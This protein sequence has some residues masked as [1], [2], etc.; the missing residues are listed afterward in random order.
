MDAI[1]MQ[2]RALEESMTKMPALSK[3]NQ[4]KDELGISVLI[5]I[6]LP[7]KILSRSTRRCQ[8]R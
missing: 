7:T 6:D 1:F 2:N 4:K 3:E 5:V 8:G